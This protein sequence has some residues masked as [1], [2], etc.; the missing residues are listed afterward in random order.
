MIE[1]DEL[2][3]GLEIMIDYEMDNYEILAHKQMIRQGI[4]RLKNIQNLI[5]MVGK[6]SSITKIALLDA[7][8]VR[9]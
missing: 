2:I 1:L 7:L 8:N 5:D 4:S 9:Q 3:S 6:S